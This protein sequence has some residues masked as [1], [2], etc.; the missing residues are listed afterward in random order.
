LCKVAKCGQ[1][2]RGRNTPLCEKH[3]GRVRRGAD[4]EKDRVAL[5]F[6]IRKEGYRILSKQEGHPLAD[7]DGRVAEHR[8]VLY[9]ASGGVCPPCSWCGKPLAWDTL[10]VDHL[11]EQKADNRPENLKG[12][13]NP[14]NRARGAVLDFIKRL[15]PEGFVEFVK[16]ADNFWIAEYL[17][18][19]AAE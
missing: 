10:V 1:V 11:N 8:M 14:C 19:Q 4:L 5:N 15:T 3:Y 18:R 16:Q 13:C 12:S 9:E 2:A 17:K 7:S 6:Y